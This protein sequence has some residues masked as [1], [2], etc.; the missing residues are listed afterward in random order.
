MNKELEAL[1]AYF[2]DRPNMERIFSELTGY[3][4]LGNSVED[5]IRESSGFED[6]ETSRIILDGFQN[7]YVF[8]DAIVSSSNNAEVKKDRDICEEAIQLITTLR[9]KDKSIVLTEENKYWLG[10]VDTR[11]NAMPLESL[12]GI[13][14]TVESLGKSHFIEYKSNEYQIPKEDRESV[15]MNRVEGLLGI[16][17]YVEN[18]GSQAQAFHL[19]AS[20]IGAVS[21]AKF[22]GIN[23]YDFI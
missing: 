19:R 8:F 21:Y 23:K 13:G 10:L 14:E 1:M 12:L 6:A 2:K 15:A 5:Y 20:I 3:V 9:S 7:I 18:N 17:S 4:R 22:I 11:V 16:K